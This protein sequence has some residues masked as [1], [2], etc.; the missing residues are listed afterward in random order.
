VNPRGGEKKRGE[1]KKGKWGAGT[2]AGG[3]VGDTEEGVK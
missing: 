3:G 2:G 1:K